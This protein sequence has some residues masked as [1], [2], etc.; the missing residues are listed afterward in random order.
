VSGECTTPDLVERT[1]KS[2]ERA[3]RRGFDPDMALWSPDAVW[4]S[5]ALRLGVTE[6]G[7]AIRSAEARAVAERLAEERGRVA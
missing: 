6:G 4:D 2:F 3:E 7:A 5:S 1:R